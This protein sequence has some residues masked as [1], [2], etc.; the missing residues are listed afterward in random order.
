MK[1]KKIC[2]NLIFKISQTLAKNFNP[3]FGHYKTHEIIRKSMQ[4]K[5]NK[6]C[7]PTREMHLLSQYFNLFH[8]LSL[9]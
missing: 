1:I 2:E 7:L 5:F 9:I 3:T 8:I 6:T 4:N